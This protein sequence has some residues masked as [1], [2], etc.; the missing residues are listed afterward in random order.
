MYDVLNYGSPCRKGGKLEVIT[1]TQRELGKGNEDWKED[2]KLGKKEV[3]Q[4]WDY[5]VREWKG[6]KGKEGG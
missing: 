2:L 1:G 5:E 4:E 6:G 3:G